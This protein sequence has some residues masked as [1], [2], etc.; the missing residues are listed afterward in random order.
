MLPLNESLL[1]FFKLYPVHLVLIFGG[2]KGLSGKMSEENKVSL[3][4]PQ[5]RD[6]LREE[7]VPQ[8]IISLM[9]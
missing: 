2:E 9:N 8:D 1:H 6:G 3:G 7:P 4:I 5:R